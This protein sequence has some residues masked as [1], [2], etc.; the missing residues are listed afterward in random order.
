MNLESEK[1]RAEDANRSKSEFLAN[2][3]HELR[4]PLNAIIGFSDVM[5]NEMLGA[6]PPRYV[7]YAS[8]YSTVAGKCLL[9]LINDV[10]NMARIESG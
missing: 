3:S 4:T 1:G 6:L 8:R 10:L 7:E 9:D 5:R 2:M